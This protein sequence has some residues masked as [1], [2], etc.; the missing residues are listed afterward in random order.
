[1]K[2][3]EKIEREILRIL[4]SRQDGTKLSRIQDWITTRSADE[5]E[6]G[7]SLLRPKIRRSGNL[8]SMPKPHSS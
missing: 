2:D 4:G 6:H 5:V 7:L 1:M 8:L 3:R